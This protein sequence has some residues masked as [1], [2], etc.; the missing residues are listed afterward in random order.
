LTAVLALIAILVAA[1]LPA[2]VLD[3]RDA[4]RTAHQYPKL[5]PV[6]SS[7]LTI[8]DESF[9]ATLA[10]AAQVF[11]TALTT[12]TLPN[13]DE[14]ATHLEILTG[15]ELDFE[16]ARQALPELGPADDAAYRTAYLT[17]RDALDDTI[18]GLHE[19]NERL[20]QLLHMMDQMPPP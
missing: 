8:A 7:V 6:A 11:E 4:A 3:L 10:R 14:V 15:K 17:L 19:T 1:V 13:R 9:D 2:A 20:A 12:Q 18:G 5:Q 16:D